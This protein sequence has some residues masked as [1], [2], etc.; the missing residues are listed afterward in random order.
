MK[1]KVRI[2]VVIGISVF[3]ITSFLVITYNYGPSGVVR[4]LDFILNKI[5]LNNVKFVVDEDG[6]PLVNY[7]FIG[8]KY[9]G[10]QRN[11]VTT[12]HKIFEYYLDYKD[13]SNVIVKQYVVNNANWIVSNSKIQ[14]NYSMLY[15]NFSWPI[16]DMPDPWRSGMAQGLAIRALGNAHEIT[17]DS[18]YLDTSDLLLNSFFVE[19]KNGGVTYKTPDDGWWYEEYA[20]ENGKESKVLNGMMHALI[21]IHEYYLYTNEPKAKFLFEKGVLALK[22]DLPSYDIEGYSYYDALETKSNEMRKTENPSIT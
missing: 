1:N 13:S 21:G 8:G 10:E 6:I 12:S 3:I 19:I 11:P 20:H 9:V 5:Y 14:G 4:T 16:Y 2:S 7:G 17:N 18:R 22:K 15:Y